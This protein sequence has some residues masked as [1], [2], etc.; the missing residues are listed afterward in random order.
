MSFGALAVNES[1]N[2]F[3]VEK[4]LYMVEILSE[5]SNPLKISCL[6]SFFS[7]WVSQ[8]S[9]SCIAYGKSLSIIVIELWS[10]LRR[11]FSILI[12]SGCFMK[13]FYLSQI[14][15]WKVCTWN[16]KLRTS[17]LTMMLKL[18]MKTLYLL[19]ERYLYLQFTRFYSNKSNVYVRYST[20]HWRLQKWTH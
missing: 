10:L 14:V 3:W 17:N 13:H 1:G 12:Y 9:R 16:G 2:D 8:F 7:K 11:L 20:N 5:A 4:T 18:L 15:K 6:P 19:K